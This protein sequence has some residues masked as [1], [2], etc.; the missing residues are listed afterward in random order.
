MGS[1]D[2][3]YSTHSWRLPIVGKTPI[4]TGRRAGWRGDWLGTGLDIVFLGR[5]ECDFEEHLHLFPER[6]FRQVVTRHC[7]NCNGFNERASFVDARAG[8][9][10]FNE[11]SIDGST[12]DAVALGKVI[13][14]HELG[15]VQLS[16]LGLV[17]VRQ[18]FDGHDVALSLATAA[19]ESLRLLK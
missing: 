19:I 13:R 17:D 8:H 2:S 12:R 16:D 4:G 1:F 5:E 18:A 7:F 10:L 3:A 6:E 9:P 14:R 15:C 11:H